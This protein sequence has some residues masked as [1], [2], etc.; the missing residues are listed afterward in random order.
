MGGSADNARERD[1]SSTVA[2]ATPRAL[3]ED[4]AS[5]RADDYRAGLGWL[6]RERDDGGAGDAW[7]PIG[8]GLLRW[9]GVVLAAT[10]VGVV[11]GRAMSRNAER[12]AFRW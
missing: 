12:D 2:A 8:L 3:F 4:D 9:S 11:I 10:S 1:V 5:H 6:G 7:T